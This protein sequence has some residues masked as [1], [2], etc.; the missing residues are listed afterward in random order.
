MRTF[1]ETCGIAL[2]AGATLMAAATPGWAAK[3]DGKQC[4]N[5]AYE[6][7]DA[8]GKTYWVCRSGGVIVSGQKTE[9]GPADG[10]AK[11]GETNIVKPVDK[12]T[13]KY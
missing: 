10:G 1:S 3:V 4:D 13:P 5:E 7:K 11:S 9:K 6:R 8:S 12:A 2:L